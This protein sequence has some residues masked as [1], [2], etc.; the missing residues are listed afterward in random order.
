MSASKLTRLRDNLESLV[1]KRQAIRWGT[2][3][4]GLL[5]AVVVI[6]VA[7]FALDF[8][9]RLTVLQRVVAWGAA[10]AV[11]AWA[12]RKYLLPFLG[13]RETPHQAALLVER[14]HQIDSDLIAALQFEEQHAAPGKAKSDWG[15]AALQSA[16]VDYVAE[17]SGG[18]NV[19]AGLNRGKLT[20]RAGWLAVAAVAVITACVVCPGHARS[21]FSRLALQNTHYPTA[22]QITALSVNGT[23]ID[24]SDQDDPL[25]IAY[26]QLVEFEIQAAGV[27]PKNGKLLLKSA[28][29]TRLIDLEPLGDASAASQLSS[30][31]KAEQSV[32]AS[33]HYRAVL[34]QLLDNLKYEV[35]LGDTFTDPCELNVIPLPVIEFQLSVTPP[36]YI[37]AAGPQP[38]VD[39]GVRQVA[40]VEGSAVG[41]TLTSSNKPLKS[42]TLTVLAK[43]GEQIP[44][45]VSYAL[46]S[47]DGQ[48]LRW[49]Y[50]AAAGEPLA[51]VADVVKFKLNVEDADQLRLGSDIEGLI[52]IKPDRTPTVSMTIVDPLWLPTGTPILDLRA[53]D[54]YGLRRLRLHVELMRAATEPR[55]EA[56][57]TTSVIDQSFPG[58]N[59]MRSTR[60]TFFTVLQADS[61]VPAASAGPDITPPPLDVRSFNPAIHGAQLPFAGSYTLDL[62][63][64]RLRKGDQVKL[65][66]DAIDDR[67]S[68]PGKATQSDP[69]F[70]QIIDESDVLAK[71]FER[72]QNADRQLNAA[73]KELIGGKP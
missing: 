26:G 29:A 61:A 51:A 24:L 27:L 31:P 54:D 12:A 14:N 9:L 37:Q 8:L 42:A 21:F 67:G 32:G 34:P 18:L 53:T 70:L 73:Q 28:S 30:N 55:A 13:Q 72:D 45:P 58:Q 23:P 40:V 50:N 47:L 11:G 43:A 35:V 22:T 56:I 7:F 6:L 49:R 63:P 20:R 1:R 17:Y 59:H 68:H 65:T 33:R 4:S 41:L 64:Y 57:P 62:A 66:L 71:L 39:P 10:L 16:V 69:L 2:G 36:D 19:F 25:K 15:S 44:E 46:K 3:Y 38:V 60:R 5:L 52:R 48:G